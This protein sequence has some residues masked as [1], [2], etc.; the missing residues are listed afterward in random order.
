[1]KKSFRISVPLLMLVAFA[2]PLFNAGI[3]SAATAASVSIQSPDPT[4]FNTSAVYTVS[5]S[6]GLGTGDYVSLSASGLPAGA[7]FSD[8]LDGCVAEDGSGN[9]SFANATV[10]TGT[11]A[12]G[13]NS[14]SADV[15]EF[16]NS[17][18]STPTGA[19]ASGAASLD[20]SIA[21]QTI[22]APA[23]PSGP[24]SSTLAVG[25]TATSGLTVTY[26]I[27]P[28]S[29][30]TGCAVNGA[31]TVSAN[32][33]G[34]CVVLLDQAGDAN[35]NAAPQVSVTAAFTAADQT[36]TVTVS[37][38]SVP[39]TST[40][41]VGSTGSH[42]TGAITLSLDTGSN[43][44]TSSGVCS[45]VGGTLSA[46][47]PGTC[48]VFAS[49][50]AGGGYNAAK[51]ADATVTFTATGKKSKTELDLAPSVVV[52]GNENS[53]VLVAEVT[54]WSGHV[55]PTGTVTFPYGSTILC[56]STLSSGGGHTMV[57]TCGLSNGQLPVGTYTIT[58][59]YSGDS[60]FAGSTSNPET[61][62]VV[63][64]ITGC[65]DGHGH[66]GH[67]SNDCHHGGGG[68]GGHGG[69]REHGHSN[70]DGQGFRRDS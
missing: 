36:I 55:A 3:A 13:S 8:S 15:T 49:I 31:G 66:D 30:A 10:T 21:D 62:T 38:T 45:L 41:T 46:S 5:W 60:N 65:G 23:P 25:A 19:T 58:A 22:T 61:L 70:G 47:G 50:A 52:T 32:S 12:P 69:G 6:G 57:A 27:D 34:T 40:V 54:G 64:Q 67:G 29:T 37:Q 35:W 53:V 17:S 24:W 63:S 39:W 43:G 56:T 51:S 26:S 59:T 28:S 9:A 4:P 20:V 48:Y 68:D 2:A 18:C 7:S 44:H 11:T 14:F 1:M 33:T 42:G 16:S